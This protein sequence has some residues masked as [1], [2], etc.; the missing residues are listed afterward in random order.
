M[1]RLFADFVKPNIF[2]SVKRIILQ[3][4][5]HICCNCLTVNLLLFPAAPEP[6]A[7]DTIVCQFKNHLGVPPAWA[8]EMRLAGLAYGSFSKYGEIMSRLLDDNN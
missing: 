3:C 6:L 7:L 4:I 2:L 5:K 8:E 1:E